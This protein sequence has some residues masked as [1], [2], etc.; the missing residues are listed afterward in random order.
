MPLSFDNLDTKRVRQGAYSEVNKTLAA[1]PSFTP[2]VTVIA[3]PSLSAERVRQES[4]GLL[5]VASFWSDLFQPKNA[6]I[7]YYTEADIDWVDAAFCQ[8][9]NFCPIGD[10]GPVSK[11]ISR[12]LPWCS[13]AQATTNRLGEPFF[14]QCLGKGSEFVKNRQ[15][16]PHEYTHW[17]QAG[18]GRM[19]S[20]PNWWIEGSA[21]YFGGV[22]GVWNG[23]EVPSSLDEVSHADAGGWSE[24]DLCPLSTP[25]VSSITNCFKYTYQRGA[26][27][28]PGSRWMMAHVSYYMGSLATEAM[29]AVKG[30]ATYKQFMTDLKT[31]PF[32]SALQAN[33]GLSADE[34]YPKVAKYVLAMYL[35]GR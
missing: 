7:G 14:N 27:P 13:S 20:Y 15:T 23:S 31:K 17:V 34:F 25:T 28:A 16:T 2:A 10:W 4:D 5:R 9:A 26:P 11:M 12:D 1:M 6:Y 8:R 29:I 30:L 18:L 32:D 35:E 33:Y 22:I 3:G 24:Q 21:A 19:D